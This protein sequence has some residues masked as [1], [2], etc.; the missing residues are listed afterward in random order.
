MAEQQKERILRFYRGSEGE[1]TAIRLIDLA[2]AVVKTAKFRLSPFLDPYGQEI[3]ETICAAPSMV[4]AASSVA[5]SRFSP[6]ATP[7][8]IRASIIRNT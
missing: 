4:C 2:E 5:V 6:A 3:A 7:P 8:S 1:E